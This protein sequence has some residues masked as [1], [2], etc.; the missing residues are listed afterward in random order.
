VSRIP[1]HSIN[2]TLTVE[3]GGR[4]RVPCNLSSLATNPLRKPV[5]PDLPMAEVRTT[6]EIVDESIDA[7]PF[8]YLGYLR[9][10]QRGLVRRW[11]LDR[12]QPTWWHI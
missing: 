10:W 2:W 8:L 5:D 12:A 9:S 6:E 1:D 7:E 3:F 11:H 4:I